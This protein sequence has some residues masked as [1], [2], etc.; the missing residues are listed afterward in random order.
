MVE[1]CG[2]SKDEA[3]R[4][5]EELLKE[6]YRAVLLCSLAEAQAG[7]P[8]GSHALAAGV[9]ANMKREDLLLLPPRGGSAFRTLR[10]IRGQH[11]AAD[12]EAGVL[13]LPRGE[14][15]AASFAL[16][17]AAALKRTGGGAMAVVLLPPLRT[18]PSPW[19]ESGMAAA[20]L[21]LP[22]LLVSKK[23]TAPR[24]ATPEQPAP[25]Y[26]TIPVD[27]DDA[28][29]AYRVAYECTARARAGQ[30]P[31]A[32]VGVPFRVRGQAPEPGAQARLE[33]L[34]RARGA[35]EK[36]WRRQIERTAVKEL[37]E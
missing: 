31:S 20:K 37:T 1:G 28:L 9:Y 35:W 17:A 7:K 34:L 29:A 3:A 15:A 25:P 10:G 26:P 33:G 5:R 6:L 32:I 18:E 24:A 8:A 36:A 23:K 14:E 11:H 21:N 12:F 27:R 16:G 19:H 2:V 4:V 13:T 22:L 30:G